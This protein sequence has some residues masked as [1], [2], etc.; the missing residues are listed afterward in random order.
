[1]EL[2][3]LGSW[4]TVQP[5]NPQLLHPNFFCAATADGRE[6]F[7]KL[8]AVWKTWQ[9]A[10]LAALCSPVLKVIYGVLGVME[11]PKGV[12]VVSL[13]LSFCV[14]TNICECCCCWFLNVLI[15]IHPTLNL[16]EVPDSGA[17]TS[18]GSLCCRCSEAPAER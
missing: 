1:M 15:F 5:G 7:V 9:E 4:S 11:K 10:K 2:C 16:P 3:I 12:H 17:Q 6:G 13:P 14:Y 8:L 18:S